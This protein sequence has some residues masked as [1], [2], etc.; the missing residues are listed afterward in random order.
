MP[1]LKP[2]SG[3]TSCGGVCRYLTRDGRALA[4]DYLN[5]DVSEREGG[6]LDWAIA[7]DAT[8][9][10]WRNDTPWGGRPYRTYKHYVLPPD[11]KDRVE[12]SALRKLSV[13]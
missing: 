12:P 1:L 9:S 13:A 7:M 8:R 3:H 11:P 4:A 5:L 10:R 2:I 6:A